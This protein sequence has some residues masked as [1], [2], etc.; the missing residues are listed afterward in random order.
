MLSKK[1]AQKRNIHG[2]ITKDVRRVWKHYLMC[3]D[4][5]LG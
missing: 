1:H 2:E 3:A 5:N 4:A